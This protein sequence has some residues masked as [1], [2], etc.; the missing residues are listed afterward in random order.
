MPDAADYGDWKTGV[1]C[2]GVLTAMATFATKLGS[3]IAQYGVS[4][5]LSLT[6]YDPN[7]TVQSA[8]TV[9]AM[10]WSN[11]IIPIVLGILA[12]LCVMPYNLDDKLMAEIN[13]ELSVRRGNA[14]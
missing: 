2:P 13:A 5:V 11:G 6:G 4:L 10:Y 7:L 1:Y 9:N 12:I 8:Q 3:A 14:E